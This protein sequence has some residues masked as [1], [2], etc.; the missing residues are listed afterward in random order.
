M[1]HARL[2]ESCRNCGETLVEYDYGCGAVA[3]AH[4]VTGAV[5][6]R[7]TDP[8]APTTLARPVVRIVV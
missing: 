2:A 7:R 5:P 1:S 8:T 3:H 4:V 6:C